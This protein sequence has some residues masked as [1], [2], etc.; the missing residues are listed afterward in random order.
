MFCQTPGSD[1]YYCLRHAALVLD[2][3]VSNRHYKNEKIFTTKLNW[4]KKLSRNTDEVL[5]I[6]E[7]PP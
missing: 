5:K 1:F 2:G 6:P 3:K 7:I 4:G